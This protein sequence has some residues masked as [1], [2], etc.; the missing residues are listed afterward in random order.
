MDK[1]KLVGF[2]FF[3]VSFLIALFCLTL[4]WPW[5]EDD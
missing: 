2:I 4:Q 5:D 3:L 1:L